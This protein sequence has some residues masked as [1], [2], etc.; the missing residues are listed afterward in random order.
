M[1]GKAALAGSAQG[2]EA[3][4]TSYLCIHSMCIQGLNVLPAAVFPLPQALVV[5]P[6]WACGEAKKEISKAYL[7]RLMYMTLPVLYKMF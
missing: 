1:V 5:Q 6:V 3:V 2:P 7:C 4:E